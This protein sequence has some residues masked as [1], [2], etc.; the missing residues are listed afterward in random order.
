MDIETQPWYSAELSAT[1]LYEVAEEW[2]ANN[3]DVDTMTQ[4][5]KD[6]I[7]D[8]HVKLQIMA[9]QE[10]NKIAG[11]DSAWSTKE[12]ELRATHDTAIQAFFQT[13]QDAEN[14]DYALPL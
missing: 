3:K 2:Y 10:K 6:D 4:E 7:V 13:K 11:F 8:G 14:D 1:E 9:R 12:T 5:E